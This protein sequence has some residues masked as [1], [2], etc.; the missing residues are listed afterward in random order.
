MSRFPINGMVTALKIANALG[1]S[2]EALLTRCGIG[3]EA[4]QRVDATIS[5]DAF[6]ESFVFIE[7]LVPPTRLPSQVMV[8]LFPISEGGLLSVAVMSSDTIGQ[9]IKLIAEFLPRI[10]PN[11]EVNLIETRHEHVIELVC[12]QS[13]GSHNG[14]FLEYLL[15]MIAK[16]RDLVETPIAMDITVAHERPKG[17]IPSSHFPE[18]NMRFGESSYSVRIA[19]ETVASAITT[20]N[21]TNFSLYNKMLRDMVEPAAPMTQTQ[22]TLM[23]IEE[24]IVESKRVTVD[25]AAEA[26][27]MSP[28]TLARRL[29][30]ENTSFQALLLRKKTELAYQYL[31]YTR[32]PI[33]HI[34]TQLGYET[35]NSF[36]RAFKKISG[37]TP[38]AFRKQHQ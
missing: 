8:E 14:M 33:N 31:R 29:E 37:V 2:G 5:N 10:L 6:N 25:R 18:C 32:K 1:A 38:L 9:A 21:S 26:V 20:R 34:A 22:C 27:N 17:V 4:L 23:F 15:G 36:S 11:I 13:I 19:K 24:S 28:R 3:E 30:A 35:T 16:G 7:A 12:T